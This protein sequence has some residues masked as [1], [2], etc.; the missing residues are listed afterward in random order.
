M[1]AIASNGFTGGRAVIDRNDPT[2]FSAHATVVKT[3]GRYTVTL[4]GDHGRVLA[5]TQFIVGKR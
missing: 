5:S 4:F 3:P 1:R 2:A